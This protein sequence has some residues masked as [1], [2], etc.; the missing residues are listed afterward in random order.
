[1]RERR[2][3]KRILIAEDDFTSRNMLAAVLRK[4]GHEVKPASPNPFR[5]NVSPGEAQGLPFVPLR[6]PQ[7]VES[8]EKRI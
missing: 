4:A 1:L 7:V 2:P 3:A 5:S 8:P 6:Y